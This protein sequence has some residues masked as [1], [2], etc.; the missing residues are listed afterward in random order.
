MH[1]FHLHFENFNVMPLTYAQA[2]MILR[3]IGYISYM[4]ISAMN[5]TY[6]FTIHANSGLS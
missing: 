6:S 2:G 5:I 4:N 3:I 1:Q